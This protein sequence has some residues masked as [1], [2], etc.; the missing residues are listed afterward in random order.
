MNTP[1]KLTLLRILAI[2]ACIFFLMMKKI[3]HNE[4]WA[5][6]LFAAASITDFIDGRLARKNNQV[7]D[8]GKFLDPLADK[9]LVCSVLICFIELGV[10][11]AVAIVC[12]IFRE[13][14][15]SSLRLVAM[16]N[17]KVI[18][19]NIWGKIKTMCQMLGI[20]LIL[21]CMELQTSGIVSSMYNF[22]IWY[23]CII[24]LMAA[25]TLISG[26]TYIVDNRKC[27]QM[28]QE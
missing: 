27:I 10:A 23:K 16:T 6:I 28:K 9:M 8:F 1:N 14:A 20:I 13:F 25:I 21:I 5:L 3:P 15:V 7:T 11:P 17:G 2:P 26:I 18:A 19:A 22:Q 12:I 4:L 24:W